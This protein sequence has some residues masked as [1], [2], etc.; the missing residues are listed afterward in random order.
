MKTET[1]IHETFKQLL[2]LTTLDSG[3]FCFFPAILMAAGINIHLGQ[4]LCTCVTLFHQ[5][6]PEK[7]EEAEKAEEVCK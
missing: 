5:V 7:G 3:K 1:P 4:I 2:F 6:Q